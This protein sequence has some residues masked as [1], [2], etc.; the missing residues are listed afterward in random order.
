MAERT[1]SIPETVAAGIP[2][3]T[4]LCVAFSGGRD[5]SVLLHVLAGLSGARAYA[6]R[7]IHVH[8]GLQAQADAW[9]RHCVGFCATLG[10]PLQVLRVEVPR[11]QGRGL[12]AAARDAR[13]RALAGVLEPGEWLLTAHHQDDQLETLLLHLMRGSGVTGLA[14]IPPA[15]DFADGR[16]VRPLLAVGARAIEAYAGIQGL[17]WL[18]DPMNDDPRL[19][20]SYLRREVIPRLQARWPAAGRAAGRSAALASEAADLLAELA[21]QDAGALVRDG[22]V[23]VAGLQALSPARQRNLLRFLV[24]RQGWPAPPE[25]RLRECLPGLLAA[26]GHRQPVLAW[27]GC[28]FRRYRGWLYLVEDPGPPVNGPPRPWDGHGCLELGG[29]RGRLRLEP[30]TGAGIRCDLAAQLAVL[31]RA[32]GERVL[33]PGDGHHRSLKY[34]FQRHGVVPWMRGHIPLIQARGELAAVADLWVAGWAA[35][36]PGEPGLRIVWD[37]HGGLR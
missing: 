15:A 16:L 37:R 24:R 6:L 3:G 21:D 25:R 14:A 4:R 26:A 2:P 34:L 30:A 23:H 27:A 8:H 18:Q 29:C 22:R 5:S 20:R 7:A 33:L 12:E 10:V 9:A 31:S 28:M 13:Y 17:A 19:D 35:A 1:T 32:G 11:D 36:A